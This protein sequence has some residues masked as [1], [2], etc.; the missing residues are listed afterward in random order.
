MPLISL[1]IPLYNAEKYLW[2][3][4]NSV[5]AQTFKDFE[6]LCINDGSTDRTEDIVKSFAEKDTRFRLINQPNAGCSAAR[7]HGLKE[8]TAPY[9]ALLDQDDMLHPQAMEVLYYLIQKGNYDVAEFVNKTVP[10]DFVLQNPPSYKLDDIKFEVYQNP[11]NFYF[12]NKRGGSVLVWNRLY[13]KDAIAGIEFPVNVQPAEDTV[14]SLKVMFHTMSLIHTDT[15]LLYYRDSSTSVMNRGIND[16]Y[17]KSHAEAGKIM[18]DYFLKSSR[19]KAAN[20]R[21]ILQKYIT[22]FIFKSV[23]SQPLRR[24][25]DEKTRLA[26]LQKAREYAVSLAGEGAL[27]PQ[28]LGVRKWL[29][30]QLFFRGNYKLARLFV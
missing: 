24:L 19:V 14:F 18:S 21:K 22:R 30:C 3:C 28:L 7:N 10:D 15:Q 13:K 27:R 17:I 8:A 4:L 6:V 20:E 9:V 12:K 16:K 1:I 5:A 29:A 26:S 2:P 11:F 23:V 25:K